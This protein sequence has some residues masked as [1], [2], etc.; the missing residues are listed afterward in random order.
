MAPVAP[1]HVPAQ[2][3]GSCHRQQEG[4]SGQGPGWAW[5]ME[6]SDGGGRRKSGLSRGVRWLRVGLGCGNGI[7][8]HK[9][10]Q[11]EDRTAHP[12]LGVGDFL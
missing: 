11:S 4:F 3:G 5:R 1:V 2:L 6:G 12:R 9:D 8:G 7:R 10:C